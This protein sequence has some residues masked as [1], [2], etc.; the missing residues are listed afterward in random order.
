MLDGSPSNII[1]LNG[2]PAPI[3]VIGL[4]NTSL[5]SVTADQPTAPGKYALTATASGFGSATSSAVTVTLPNLTLYYDGSSVGAG[6]HRDNFF[7]ALSNYPTGGLTVTLTSADTSLATVTPSV[8]FSSNQTGGYYSIKGLKVGSVKITASATGW[9]SSTITINLPQ[10]TFYF[11]GIQTSRTV[12]GAANAFTVTATTPGCGS[13]DLVNA[14]VV[15]SFSVVSTPTGIET[16]TPTTVTIPA[17][18]QTS[19]TANADPPTA[20]GTYN[21]IAKSAAFKDGVSPSVTVS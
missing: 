15:V 1:T 13:C 17:N 2:K 19:P 11:N 3:T 16:V 8:T 7:I 14:D 5:T 4:A 9:N 20:A 18:S 6:M 12:K 21:I 10:P